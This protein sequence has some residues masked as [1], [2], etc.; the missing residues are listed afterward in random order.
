MLIEIRN[1][2]IKIVIANRIHI[3]NTDP[4][5]NPA[6]DKKADPILIWIHNHLVFM[7]CVPDPDP[8]LRIWIL[9]LF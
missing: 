8:R 6:P 1:P 7:C 4:E 9:L 5:A 2:D 3:V